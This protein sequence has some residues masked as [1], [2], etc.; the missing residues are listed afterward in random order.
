MWKCKARIFY[1]EIMCEV[2]GMDKLQ[3]FIGAIAGIILAILSVAAGWFDFKSK[4]IRKQTAEI[5]LKGL[6][7]SKEIEDMYKGDNGLFSYKVRKHKKKKSDSP[8]VDG[9]KKS[10]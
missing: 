7:E 9:A 6:K 8:P 3:L 4:R 10:S 1:R 2:W 5:N